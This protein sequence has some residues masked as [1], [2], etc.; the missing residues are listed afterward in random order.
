MPGRWLTARAP[1]GGRGPR[2]ITLRWANG[3]D[4][5]SSDIRERWAR[6]GRYGAGGPFSGFTEK[7]LGIPTNTTTA[8]ISKTII[9]Q[10]GTEGNP[11]RGRYG[12]NTGRHG[13]VPSPL[14]QTVRVTFA[15]T[16]TGVTVAGGAERFVRIRQRSVGRGPAAAGFARTPRAKYPR[17]CTPVPSA[18]PR[19]ISASPPKA[20]AP[21]RSSR[22]TAP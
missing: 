16:G 15:H 1:L 12:Q 5:T 14:R 6:R 3:S 18:T 10:R 17:N 7:W 9:S 19:R 21:K 13:V 8:M 22:K 11:A 20:A 4:T 2:P